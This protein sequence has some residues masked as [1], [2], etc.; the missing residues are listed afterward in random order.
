MYEPFRFNASL[1][2]LVLESPGNSSSCLLVQFLFFFLLLSCVPC[3][4][5]SMSLGRDNKWLRQSDSIEFAWQDW[6]CRFIK[7]GRS[8]HVATFLSYGSRSFKVITGSIVGA[9]ES[10]NYNAARVCMVG[11]SKEG[12][13][14]ANV[15]L[16][17]SM[18]RFATG[19]MPH[20]VKTKSALRITCRLFGSQV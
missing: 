7:S 8:S 14:S 18:G 9:V 10:A 17:S 16:R 1:R 19:C 3:P 2:H 13:A 6:I 20:S 12:V 15:T 11:P 4:L 5:R